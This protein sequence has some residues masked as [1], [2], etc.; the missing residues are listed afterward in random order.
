MEILAWPEVLSIVEVAGRHEHNLSRTAAD[1]VDRIASLRARSCSVRF[2]CNTLNVSAHTVLEVERRH[3][4]LV[5]TH[6][7]RLATKCEQVAGL[8]VEA[9][10]EK[11]IA[12]ELKVGEMG[13]N[14]GILLTK[15][16][17]LRGGAAAAARASEDVL[18]VETYLDR[19]KRVRS[20]LV[21]VTVPID[22]T[23]S[24]T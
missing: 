5:A 17:E 23:T 21:G 1:L 11:A 20:K 12:G 8:L 4:Q 9:I 15:A 13:L 18:S 3:P 14:A 24:A 7:E 10:E 6:K 16:G 19:M 22:S 2:V